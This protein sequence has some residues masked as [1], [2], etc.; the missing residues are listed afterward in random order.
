VN[1]ITPLIKQ[2][3]IQLTDLVSKWLTSSGIKTLKKSTKSNQDITDC[4]RLILRAL[5]IIVTGYQTLKIPVKDDLKAAIGTG[6]NIA[7]L[8]TNPDK[9]GNL[10][11]ENSASKLSTINHALEFLH[12]VYTNKDNLW[13]NVKDTMHADLWKI[14]SSADLWKLNI[15]NQSSLIPKRFVKDLLELAD[16][17]DFQSICTSMSSAMVPVDFDISEY[18]F[19]FKNS[20]ANLSFLSCF[21]RSRQKILKTTVDS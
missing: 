15:E 11:G 12:A 14:C 21:P 16:P 6:V 7:V 10:H 2:H 1:K 3:A 13:G 4:H 5:E 20:V 18:I 8:I 9:L 17:A 19:T